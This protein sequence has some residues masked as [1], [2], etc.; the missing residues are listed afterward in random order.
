MCGIVGIYY[1]DD[2]T[3]VDKSILSSMNYKI[4]HRGPDSEGYFLEKNVGL[5][6]RRLSIIDIKTGDQP[7]FNEDGSIAIVYN[8]ELYN[9]HDIK[10]ELEKKGHIF[11]T[12]SDTETIVHAYEE[13][14]TDCLK[15]FNGMF[16]FA[17]WDKNKK[18]LFIARDR[19]GIKPLYYYLDGEKFIF[20]SEIK[21]IV[22]NPEVK[23]R[24]NPEALSDFLMYQ[25]ILDDKTFFMD[26]KKLLPGEFCVCTKKGMKTSKYW[27]VKFTRSKHESEY[28]EKEYCRI[29]EKSVTE[30]LLSDVPLGSY[31]SGGFDSTTVATFATRN[32]KK[33]LNTFTG[34]FDDGKKYSE[35]NTARDVAKRINSKMYSVKITPKDFISNIKDIVYHLDEP[36]TGTGSFPQYMVS[37][38]V[39]EHVTVVLTGHGGDE[40]FAGYQVFKSMYYKEQIK[41][42]PLNIFKILYAVKPS[43]FAKVMYYMF[44][45]ILIDPAVKYG[46]FIMFNKKEQKKMLSEDFYSDLEKYDPLSVVEKMT[47]NKRFT[48]FERTQY[49]YIKT[50]LPTLFILEDKV[51]MAHSIEAR[52]PICGNK[53][54]DF[55]LTIPTEEKMKN[56]MLKSVTKRA[57]KDI[58]P[59][60]VYKQPKMGFPTPLAKWFK[61]PLKKFAYDTLLSK[62]TKNRNIFNEDYIRKLLDDNSRSPTDNLYDYVRANKIFSL[63]T[64]EL[65]FQVFIDD[66]GN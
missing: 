23:A 21:A 49:L 3:K 15:M 4:K 42:N 66:H 64:I 62:K 8:G 55:A 30:H 26:I 13:Y 9:F 61:G 7:I 27:D 10:N 32:T 60:S 33:K 12:K 22:K 11:K 37:K 59:E 40:L 57:M 47:R 25:N 44:Y 54:V 24:I 31:L 5:A 17:I 28:F 38:L 39:S 63:I 18:Q 16:A 45:P 14:G 46:I 58:L 19:L 6:N 43:E 48:D 65:W 2:K 52:T 51:G 53:V 29:V 36:T 56:D 41:K 1:F 50:Y 20:S 35:I 34:Y